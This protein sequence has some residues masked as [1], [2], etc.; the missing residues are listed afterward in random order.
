MSLHMAITINA[1][2]AAL[3][4]NIELPRSFAERVSS[5]Y[6]AVRD[7]LLD[8]FEYGTQI[9]Q[10]GSFQ[11][12]TK[13][14]PSRENPCIDLD[15]AVVLG[16]I[17]DCSIRRI[18]PIQILSGLLKVL[19]KNKHYK[20]MRPKQNAPV[21]EL[22]YADDFSMELVPCFR[23]IP[24]VAGLNDSYF[25]SPNYKDWTIA[26]YDD[27]AACLTRINQE[28]CA[29]TL[30]PFIKQTK[31]LMRRYKQFD[32][33]RSIHLEALCAQVY[34]TIMNEMESSWLPFTTAD[35]LARFLTIAPRIITLSVSI[36]GSRSTAL[37]SELTYHELQ[38]IGQAM[39]YYG[40]C[41]Q[42]VSSKPIQQ[43]IDFWRCLFGPTF[44]V[45]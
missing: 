1:A 10:I 25:V 2:F 27:D 12:K 41:A 16:D 31:Y 11:R 8:V 39:M 22:A 28:V 36:P 40:T 9:R 34:P 44:P 13:V 42:A 45:A 14:K 6:A 17:D 23:Q 21:I 18:K 3:Q 30:I 32:K 38:N 37:G 7:H 26:N 33:M 43:Q 4:S 29:G 20:N 35:Y 19:Q 5:R 15:I 24:L